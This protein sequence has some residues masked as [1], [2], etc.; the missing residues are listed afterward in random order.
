[1]NFQFYRFIILLF[2]IQSDIFSIGINKSSDAQL[3]SIE[4]VIVW[5]SSSVGIDSIDQLSFQNAFSSVGLLPA[6]LTV[7]EFTKT[8]LHKNMLI[9]LPNSSA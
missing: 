5:N 2:L 7:K 3:E 4:T 9:I 6:R 1:M 8:V